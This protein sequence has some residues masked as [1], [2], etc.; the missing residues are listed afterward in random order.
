MAVQ[1]FLGKQRQSR[2]G[3][4][5]ESNLHFPSQT[6][7]IFWK[8]SNFKFLYNFNS[9]QYMYIA[10]WCLT[11]LVPVQVP[12]NFY[13]VFYFVHCACDESICEKLARLNISQFCYTFVNFYF[14]MWGPAP[15]NFKFEGVLA[16]FVP[17]LCSTTYW[18]VDKNMITETQVRLDFCH[19]LESSYNVS[20]LPERTR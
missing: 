11:S 18:I 1:Q 3:K 20:L 2:R 10:N 16:S 13:E 4:E 14:K 7:L 9:V 15:L 19:S 6:P 5:G 8:I 12:A 17:L